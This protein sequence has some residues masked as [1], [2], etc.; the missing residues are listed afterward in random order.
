METPE[1]PREVAS[2]AVFG[3]A[4]ALSAYFAVEEVVVRLGVGNPTVAVA[5]GTVAA[6][7]VGLAYGDVVE[8]LAE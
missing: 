8:M 5:V 1:T 6:F 4:V 7:F 3:A 2:Y